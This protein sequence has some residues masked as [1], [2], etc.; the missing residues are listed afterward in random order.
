MVVA[1]VV[2]VPD[3]FGVLPDDVVETFNVG[4]LVTEHFYT[5]SQAGRVI[6]VRRNGREVVFQEDTV[7]IDPSFKPDIIPGGFVGHCVNQSEQ[8]YTYSAN[9]EGR[10]SVHTL[11]TW[12]GRKCWT[13]KGDTPTGRNSIGHGQRKFYDYNF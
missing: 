8:R 1:S 5:D 9:P 12:R 7:I 10:I 2:R 13:R 6:E 11:R 4:D 3:K